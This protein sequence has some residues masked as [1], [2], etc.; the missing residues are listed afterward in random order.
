MSKAFMVIG[1]MG[2]VGWLSQL[3]AQVWT[4]DDSTAPYDCVLDT[5]TVPNG[6]YNLS[7]TAC[8]AAGNCTTDTILITVANPVQLEDPRFELSAMGDQAGQA[9]ATVD[10][11]ITNTAP[12]PFGAFLVDLQLPAPNLIQVDSLRRTARYL[13]THL[14]DFQP[15][16]SV[17]IRVVGISTAADSLAAGSGSVATLFVTIPATVSPASYPLSLVNGTIAESPRTT[18]PTADLVV[19]PQP[20]DAT[21]DGTITVAD[22]IRIVEILLGR[23][24]STP[25]ADC[26]QDGA[27]TLGDAICTVKKILGL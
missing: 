12:V 9:G 16:D 25:G 13:P 11:G 14:L 19:G 27:I 2:I 5:T 21:G 10:I 20:G 26:N 23:L 3:S 15:I 6:Q 24:A 7:A 4:C 18:V 22:V 17:T 1:L 8:D